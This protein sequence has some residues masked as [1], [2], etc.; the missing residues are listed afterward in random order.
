[1]NEINKP[2]FT[3]ELNS[4]YLD[5]IIED[6]LYAEAEERLTQLAADHNDLIGAAINL[7]R[8]AAA[9]TTY[10]HE[11]TVVV[12]GRPENIAASEKESNAHLALKLALDAA[13]RQIRKRR[14]KLG[15]PWEQPG[16]HPAEQEIEEL[17]AAESAL[18]Q[19]AI[20]TPL[21]EE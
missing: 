3:L 18:I 14:E 16:N 7:R 20:E 10:L 9:E 6:E 15:K 17:V 4:D 8:P 5:D 12:Y 11:A 21:E 19:P 2:D 13:E 1:M